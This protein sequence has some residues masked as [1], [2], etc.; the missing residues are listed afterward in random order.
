[1]SQRKL[2]YN[3]T[4]LELDLQL[5]ALEPPEQLYHGTAT[6][7]TDS[8]LEKGLLKAARHH[9]HLSSEKDTAHKVGSRHGKPLVL[10]VN[11]GEM[12]KNGYVFYCSENSVWLTNHVPVEFISTS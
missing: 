8:I 6:R 5:D 4:M 9:V 1:M 11:S 10:K 7:F 2:A 3:L 12:H